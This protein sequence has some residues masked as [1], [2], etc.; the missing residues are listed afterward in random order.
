MSADM[1][2]AMARAQVH[3]RG[4]KRWAKKA[5][6]QSRESADFHYRRWDEV[7]EALIMDGKHTVGQLAKLLGRTRYAIKTKRKKLNRLNAQPAQST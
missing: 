6:K 2:R 7:E 4:C 5:N 3:L 1:Y